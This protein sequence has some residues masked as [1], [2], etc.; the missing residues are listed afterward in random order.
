MFRAARTIFQKEIAL[1]WRTRYAVNTLLAFTGASLL[2]IL[3][4]LRADQMDPTPKSGLVWIVILFAAMAGMMRTFVYE[5]EKKTWKLLQLHSTASAV[6]NG[7]LAYNILFLLALILFTF[8][9]YL[10]MMNLQIVAPLYFLS[11]VVF[12]AVGLAAVTTLTSAMIARADRRGA[13]F[14]VLCIPLV[15]PLLLLLT[16]VT[17]TA[18]VEGP[19]SDSLND[20][21]A[22]IG[23]CGVTI[24]AGVLLFDYIWEE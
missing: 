11:A 4:T 8:F 9:F 1:E 24:T 18:I 14:S 13:I 17:R 16:S 21:T 19:G 10:L 5:F 15:V 20:I 22:L 3:F 7:K 2:V 6:Y 12:G 23:Y